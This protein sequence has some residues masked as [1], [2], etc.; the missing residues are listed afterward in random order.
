MAESQD[1]EQARE[2]LEEVSGEDVKHQQFED[3]LTVRTIIGSLFVGFIMMPGAMYLGLVA[4][5]GLGPAAA[6]VTV[7]L[8][9]EIARRSFQP[10]KKQELYMLLYIAGG[11]VGAANSGFH[12]L[13]WNQY[14]V[15]CP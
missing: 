14:L 1:I 13:I 5:Q 6:W 15:Q 12:A 11:L 2:V 9:S 4:G 3:G 7:V 8:F 10:L